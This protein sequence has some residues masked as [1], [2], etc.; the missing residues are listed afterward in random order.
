MVG[1]LIFPLLPVQ[2]FTENPSLAPAPPIGFNNWA[3]FR[4]DLNETLL[5]GTAQAMLK[6]GLLDVEYDRLTLDDCWMTAGYFTTVLVMNG[7]GLLTVLNRG[8]NAA[9][10]TASLAHLGLSSQS[11]Y[12]YDARDLVADEV[13]TIGSTIEIQLDSH[14]AKVYRI[15]LPESCTKT[16]PSG[17]VFGTPSDLCMTASTDSITFERCSASDSQVW[18]VAVTGDG[19]K[20]T[21]SPLSD[22]SVCLAA[23]NRLSLA[24]CH[25]GTDTTWYN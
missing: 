8:A 4:C 11:S 2:A 22:V 6:C 25:A 12:K 3:R 10:T 13:S 21:L 20:L 5:T 18:H 24:N 14:V 15:S 9:T 19:T 7:D 17:V 23:K 16:T 1:L